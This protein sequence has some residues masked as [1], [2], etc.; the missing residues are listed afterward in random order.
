MPAFRS[1]ELSFPSLIE[2]ARS[3]AV[4]VDD[5]YRVLRP[6]GS[7]AF[8]TVMLCADERRHGRLVAVKGVSALSIT[9]QG[10]LM[11]EFV[12]ARRMRHPNLVS[13]LETGLCPRFGLYLVL[14]YV[15]GPDMV[16]II[17]EH[18]HVAPDIAA[19]VCRQIA[20]GLAHMHRHGLVHR[21][22]KPD[23]VYLE[24]ARAKLGDFGASRGSGGG[25]ATVIFTPGYAPPETAYGEF[26]EATD[27]YALGAFFHLA[28]TGKL[29]PSR[30]LRARNASVSPLLRKRGGAR[31]HQLVSRLLTPVADWR[32]SDMEV[33]SRR[34]ALLVKPSTRQRLRRLVERAN[35][36][37]DRADLERRWEEFEHKHHAALSP[38][39][40]KWVCVRCQGPVSEAMLMCPWCGD[41]L[42]FR[43]EAT[44][45]RYCAR[46]EHGIHEN[47]RYCPWCH[48]T[49]HQGSGDGQRHGDRRYTDHCDG[50]HKP[51]MPF[52]SCCPWCQK[53]HRWEV[54]GMEKHCKGC[55]WTVI[56]ELFAW[57]P[58][59]GLE[60]NEK[61]AAQ[62]EERIKKR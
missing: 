48:E 55:G 10:S 58:W 42:R 9:H 34:F 62:A 44:F 2:E 4:H 41:L 18:G 49:F 36:E 13:V 7:G 15:D 1:S 37:R 8:A 24:G 33:I 6:L 43:S 35:L 52:S 30:T 11:H 61:F 21:D 27:A 22:V 17:D 32:L 23:N 47:W 38:F 39:G 19:E 31:A 26:A 29:P 45:P 50:C 51:L 25:N 56:G 14:E 46:C 3:H 60:Q 12:N 59:C 5:R 57:C 28:V 40:V 54:P 20:K 16:K 53:E